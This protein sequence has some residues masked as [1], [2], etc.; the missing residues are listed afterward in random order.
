[1]LSATAVIRFV[2]Y[3]LGSIFQRKLGYSKHIVEFMYRKRKQPCQ[4]NHLTRLLSPMKK[5][6]ERLRQGFL[7][8]KQ[9]ADF[10]SKS[11]F[12][13]GGGG[14]NYCPPFAAFRGASPNREKTAFLCAFSHFRYLCTQP[15]KCKFSENSCTIR[16]RI[17]DHNDA[18]CYNFHFCPLFH[19]SA[20][21]VMPQPSSSTVAVGAS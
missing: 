11:A 18:K 13:Y 17:L 14:G 16:V 3:L 12:C 10:L 5:P 21:S 2:G 19:Q 1:M 8:K 4:I 7:I 9:N 6:Q 20:Q 15:Q